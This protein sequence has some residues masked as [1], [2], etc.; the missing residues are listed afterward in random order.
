MEPDFIR[1][2]HASQITLPWRY[3][4][5]YQ[6]IK[7]P[8]MTTNQSV[9]LPRHSASVLSPAT[10]LPFYTYKYVDQYSTSINV[11]IDSLYP[12]PIKVPALPDPYFSK[13]VDVSLKQL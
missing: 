3:F 4:L 9:W 6:R 8:S 12:I 7:T 1:H 2:S 11:S 13:P 5:Q 10:I